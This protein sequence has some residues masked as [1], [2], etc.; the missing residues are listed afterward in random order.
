MHLSNTRSP[1]WKQLCARSP[2]EEWASSTM[3]V[4]S[5]SVVLRF[6]LSVK[7]SFSYCSSWP[8][9]IFVTAHRLSPVVANRRYPRVAVCGLLLWTRALDAWASAVATQGLSCSVACGIFPDQE[10]NPWPRLR[11][12]D[13]LSTPPP[14]KSRQFSLVLTTAS[15]RT[16]NVCHLQ[17]SIWHVS[18]MVLEWDFKLLILLYLPCIVLRT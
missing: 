11:Q 6:S 9:W 17:S 8:H 16:F 7:G 18:V 1:L 4:F 2:S 15:P 13:S 3:I 12:A 5:I 14:G 10:S